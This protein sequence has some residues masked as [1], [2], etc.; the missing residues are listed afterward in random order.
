M[1]FVWL[2]LWIC[3]EVALILT[4][5]NGATQ[6]FQQFQT[7]PAGYIC[8]DSNVALSAPR[9]VA[10]ISLV[11]DPNRVFSDDFFRNYFDILVSGALD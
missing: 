7:S 10:V 3:V 8:S 2:L 9:V 11:A 6:A 4:R 1:D 5:F